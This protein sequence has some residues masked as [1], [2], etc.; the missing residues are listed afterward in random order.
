MSVC[1][2][3]WLGVMVVCCMSCF[4]YAASE[5][6]K[7]II[8]N[9]RDPHIKGTFEKMASQLTN[10]AAKNLEA[11][12]FDNGQI[13]SI[14]GLEQ[15]TALR[16]LSLKHNFIEKINPLQRLIELENLDLSNNRIKV[17]TILTNLSRLKFLNIS[18]N[19][20]KYAYCCSFS[21]LQQLNISGNQ[22]QQLIFTDGCNN[23]LE[24]ID[25]SNNPLLEIKSLSALSSLKV[26]KCNSTFINN[27]KCFSKLS[28]LEVL[29]V[30][31]C[32]NLKHISDL[33]S[34]SNSIFTCKL[35][36]LKELKVSEEFLEGESK[37][38]LQALRNGELNR[39]FKLNG[40]NVSN[41]IISK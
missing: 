19:Q 35:P 23:L 7:Q 15:F 22:I 34:K 28:G 25:V 17:P 3:R 39:P 13:I 8:D 20:I 41:Q 5:G 12:Q 29:E 21:S 33:F 16:T 1:R 6:V 27:L 10:F 40:K 18:D 4:A 2:N 31:H 38:L 24:I 30:E 9:I 32:C 11:F 14:Q 26:F 36:N 37:D